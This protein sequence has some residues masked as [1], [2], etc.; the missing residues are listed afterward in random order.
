VT[1]HD[2]YTLADL[3]AYEQKHNLANGEENRDGESN[4]LSWN[5]GVEGPTSDPTI[6]D[7]RA[8]QRRNFFVTLLVSQGVPM[9]SGGD[10]V[11][12]TQLGNNNAYCHDSP[13]SWTPWEIAADAQRFQAFVTRVLAIRRAQPALRRQTFLNGRAPPQDVRWLRPEGGDFED[14]DWNDGDR[15]TIGVFLDGAA[16]PETDRGVPVTDDMVLILING[17]SREVPFA[18]PVVAPGTNWTLVID[19]AYPESK[20][21]GVLAGATMT[22]PA[23]SV[24]IVIGRPETSG[25]IDYGYER[26]DGYDQIRG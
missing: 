6:L 22:L 24:A 9:I 7:L 19:T 3:V 15:Q 11:G 13:V 17:A 1:A 12:R 8:R 5:G 18:L 21:S 25:A 16:I 20:A 23:R 2:G 10:E 26:V 4:N 14:A